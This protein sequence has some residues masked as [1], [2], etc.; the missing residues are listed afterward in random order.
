MVSSSSDSLSS[1]LLFAR[2]RSETSQRA[3]LKSVGPDFG[4]KSLG[5]PGDKVDNKAKGKVRLLKH[6]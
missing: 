6:V 1:S 2:K 3:P 5:R 4:R